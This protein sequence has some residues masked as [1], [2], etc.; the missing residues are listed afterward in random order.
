[1]SK[2]SSGMVERKIGDILNK[3]D[4]IELF[5]F[6]AMSKWT[7]GMVERKLGDKLNKFDLIELFL[8][9]VTISVKL[10]EWFLKCFLRMV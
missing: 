4:L 10:S 5:W 6:E 9:N 2:W 1:M 3:F 7:S 8:D